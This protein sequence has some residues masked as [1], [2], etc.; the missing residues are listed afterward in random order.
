MF[1]GLLLAIVSGICFSNCFI[2]VR[3]IKKFAWENIWFIFSLFGVVIFPIL[4]GG[5]TIPSMLGLY[6]EIGWRMNLLVIAAGLLGGAGAVMYGL[7]LV[8]IGMAQ[9]NGLGNGISVVV[10]AFVPLIIQHR[11]AMRGRL[12]LSLLLGAMFGVLGV[13][14]CALAASQ[15]DQESAY[16]DPEQQKGHSHAH[17][18][19]VGVLLAVGY[20]LTASIMNF[21]LAF[22]DDY[23]K[24]A[25]THG[26]SEVFAANAFYIPMCFA[27][28]LSSS[29]YYGYLWKKNGTLAQFR[30]PKVL[31]YWLW[32][33]LI[34]AIWFFGGMILYGW[35]MPWMKSYGPVVGW[36]VCL[37]AST[38]SCAVVEYCYGDWKGRPLRTLSFGLVALSTSIAV[39]GYVSWL[40][41][42]IA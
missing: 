3:H 32:C 15:R 42:I 28:F 35:A 19:F 38:L 34:A 26:T 25:R 9:V 22:A 13:V 14:I 18:A 20:G 11:E 2:P 33:T 23:M 29:L 39:F 12:G 37:T 31:R 24:L 5:L 27:N 8:R 7:S 10:G 16:M 21:G 6:R 41:Q 1:I 30:G 36:P 40:I 17:T 4:V